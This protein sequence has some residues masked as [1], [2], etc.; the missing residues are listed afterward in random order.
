MPAPPPT[1]GLR[2]A[3]SIVA[4]PVNLRRTTK[5]ALIVGTVLFAINQADVVMGGD[6]TMMTWVK[7]ALTFVVPFVVSNLGVVHATRLHRA[8]HG[9]DGLDHGL[10]EPHA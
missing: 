5:I 9:G 6:A 7:V 8:H 2:D 1:T 10:D 3:L 4:Q